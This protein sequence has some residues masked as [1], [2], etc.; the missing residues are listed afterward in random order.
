ME[1][2]FDPNN[3]NILFLYFTVI[4]YFEDL[5][6]NIKVKTRLLAQT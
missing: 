6:T 2:G 1:G 4:T 5:G 3:S